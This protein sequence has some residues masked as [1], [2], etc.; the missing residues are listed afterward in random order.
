MIRFRFCSIRPLVVRL[1]I[2]VLSIGA[3]LP[4]ANAQTPPNKDKT[5]GQQRTPLPQTDGRV[6]PLLY[7][8]PLLHHLFALG[9]INGGQTLRFLVDT[10]A[11][12]ALLLDARVARRLNL[13]LT[14]RTV[15]INPGARRAQISRPASVQLDGLSGS[16]DD[17]V[18][19]S[20]EI[21]VTDLSG[22]ADAEGG[23]PLAGIIGLPLL[24][25]ATVRL[26]FGA[27]TMTLFFGE[28]PRL[29]LPGTT[30]LPLVW[31]EDAGSFLVSVTTAPA[32][33]SV[34]LFLDTG[35]VRTSLPETIVHRLGPLPTIS[36]ETL[37]LGGILSANAV[38]LPRLCLGGREIRNLVVDAMPPSAGQHAALLGLDALSRFRSVT[39]D[40]RNKQITLEPAEE[41][42]YRPPGPIIGWT[43]ALLSRQ[44]DDYVVAEVTPGS[45]ASEAG[46]RPGE[47]L[48]RVDGV[49]PAAV[50]IVGAR[51]LLAG[52][53]RT[54]AALVLE[55]QTGP[56]RRP[57]TVTFRRRSEFAAPARSSVRLNLKRAS[58]GFLVITCVEVTGNDANPPELGAGDEIVRI[59]GRS[60]Q[61][62]SSDDVTRELQQPRLVLLVRTQGFGRPRTVRLRDED[63]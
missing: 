37:T 56:D 11:P 61:T 48:V 31:D 15:T 23:P 33:L 5:F 51:R 12:G 38:L 55:S 22:V 52:F 53:N 43:G 1:L 2:V 58:S 60:T 34:P 42:G 39:L 9:R 40:F 4:A 7:S 16:R 44:G 47:R 29:E 50:G 17:A 59:N 19:P 49:S 30:N 24:Q 28:H 20:V 8:P 3:W 63:K 54:N 21:A 62:L 13:V 36:S 35:A 18:F 6:V 45:P 27:K 41:T 26:D 32:G 25:E 10:G 14:D 57:R 46:V